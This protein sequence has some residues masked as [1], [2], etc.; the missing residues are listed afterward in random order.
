MSGQW[1]NDGSPGI[2]RVRWTPD[3]TGVVRVLFPTRLSDNLQAWNLMNVTVTP[4]GLVT[5]RLIKQLSESAMDVVQ[6]TFIEPVL[7]IAGL[8]TENAAFIYWKELSPL[9]ATMKTAKVRGVAVKDDASF[10]SV[11]DISP[12]WTPVGDTNGDGLAEDKSGDYAK[13]GFYFHAGLN[14]LRYVV[15]WIQGTSPRSLHVRTYAIPR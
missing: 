10:T 13:G 2:S 14:Q 11:F 3:G 8:G 1:G 7:S 15:P 5:A 4:G 12:A 9:S 6:A